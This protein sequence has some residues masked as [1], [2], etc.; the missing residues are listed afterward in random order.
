V[1]NLYVPAGADEPDLSN[2]KF[3]HKLKVLDRMKTLYKKRKGAV[4][5]VLVGD[6]NVAPGEHDVWSHKQL[7]KVVSHTPGETDRLNAVRDLGGFVDLARQ[8]RPDPEKLFTWWSYRSPDWT[9]NNRG[10]RLDHI[11]ATSDIAAVSQL[12]A[13]QI[14]VPVRSWERPSDHVPVVAG[15]KL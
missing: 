4:P 13:F 1:H 7:L 11:W 10:R 3:A 5:T 2:P 15:L 9:K 12:E 8:H 6:L 14:H